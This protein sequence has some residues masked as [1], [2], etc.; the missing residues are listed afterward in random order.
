[1]NANRSQQRISVG[2]VAAISMLQY[3]NCMLYW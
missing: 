2:K 3:Q 1:M